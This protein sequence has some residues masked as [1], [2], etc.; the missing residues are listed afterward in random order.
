MPEPQKA[1]VQAGAQGIVP[2]PFTYKSVVTDR[3]RRTGC[4]CM[5]RT[6]PEFMENRRMPG[7]D[8]LLG[9]N[10]GPQVRRYGVLVTK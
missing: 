8:C 3:N 9:K 1:K 6:N 2:L 4:F 5:G 10:R 7:F